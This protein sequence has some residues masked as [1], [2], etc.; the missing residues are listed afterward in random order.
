[1][2]IADTS[3]ILNHLGITS[4]IFHNQADNKHRFKAGF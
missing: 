2:D 4:V 1:V 3:V